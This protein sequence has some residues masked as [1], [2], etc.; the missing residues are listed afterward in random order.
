MAK[1]LRKRNFF[2]KLNSEKQ[3]FE[4]FCLL[5]N[6]STM[7]LLPPPQPLNHATF[8][9]STTT[10]PCNF[11]LFHNHSTM[12]LLPPPQPLNHATF[13]SSTT[14]QPCNSFL[15][16]NHST[17]QLLPLPQP[18]NHATFA[19]SAKTLK[20]L[21]KGDKVLPGWVHRPEVDVHSKATYIRD[22]IQN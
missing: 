21:S 15:L 17:M 1:L 6:H 19:S 20:A 11:C 4:F 2:R 12:Q 14:T 16:H 22:T 10:Q 8:A 7:Q 3:N 5:H 18:L 13:A 9:S